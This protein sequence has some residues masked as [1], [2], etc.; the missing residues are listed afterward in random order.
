MKRIP[1]RLMIALIA[2][3][4]FGCASTDSTSRTRT[5]RCASER[6]V[7]RGVRIFDVSTGTM[8]A[9]QD[10]LIS[11]GR[12]SAV[13]ARLATPS[14]TQ[15]VDCSGKYAL[16]GLFDCHTHLVHLTQETDEDLRDKL[17]AF[18]TRGITQVR[19]VGGPIDV[20]NGLSRRITSGEIAGPE[21]F[22]SG[23]MLEGSPLTYSELNEEFPGFTVALDTRADV[24]RV[25]PDLARQGASHVKIFNKLDRDVYRHLV[26]V[27][28]RCALRVV[29]DPGPPLFHRITMDDALDLG[30]TSFEHAKAPW[31]V[32]LTDELREEHD[33]LVSPEASEM[34]QMFF[35]MKVSALGAD[36]ASVE[37]LQQLADKMRAKGACLCPTLQ[38]FA[39]A[40]ELAI[41]QIKQ[42]QH[43][44]EIPEMMR[45]N[46]RRSIAG[47][48]AVSCLVVRE[49][50]ARGV[51]LL[52]GQDGADPAATFAEMRR[53]KACGVSEAEIIKGATIYPA[54]WLGVDDRLGALA[55]DRQANILVVNGNPLEDISRVDS[56]FLVFQNGRLVRPPGE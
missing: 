2:A 37:R 49:L 5:D 35:M 40:E 53:L 29:Y 39:V 47:M 15:Q 23:P 8:N 12:I 21:L 28:Q 11:D 48:E 38:V 50:A 42:E 43:L 14:G 18:V 31:P 25:L 24:D 17:A 9:A 36:S 26:D 54:Q 16:P 46:I 52:V 1:R 10:I 19:D 44:T 51:R 30:V 34:R 41:E 45:A 22:Y 27:A 7:L 20:L 13:G 3:V 6:I 32:I 4:C 33:E 55:P 56:T